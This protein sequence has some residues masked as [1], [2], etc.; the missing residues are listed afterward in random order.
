M[1]TGNEA[2]VAVADGIVHGRRPETQAIACYVEAIKDG[3]LFAGRWRGLAPGQAGHRDEGR[4]FGGRRGGGGIT[5]RFAGRQ[6]RG[7]RRRCAS[8]GLSGRGPPRT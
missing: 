8:S 3:A 1:S 4:R 2:D 5:H 6:R 7:L